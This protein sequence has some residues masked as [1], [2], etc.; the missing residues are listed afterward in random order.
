MSLR[1]SAA[2]NMPIMALYKVTFDIT[3]QCDGAY[4]INQVLTGYCL[5][6]QSFLSLASSFLWLHVQTGQSHTHTS[7]HLLHFFWYMII[8]MTVINQQ[9]S[10]RLSGVRV[11]G[12]R[13]C[14]VA[15]FLF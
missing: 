8:I 6:T 7:T 14:E 4:S 5:A 10:V 9:L 1:Y 13:C 11:E 2:A 3:P 15:P 12:W